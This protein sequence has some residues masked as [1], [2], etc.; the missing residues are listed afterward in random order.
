M[1]HTGEL[2]FYCNECRTQWAEKGNCL[3]KNTTSVFDNTGV[4]DN[5][6][7]MQFMCK[8]CNYVLQAHIFRHLEREHTTIDTSSNQNIEKEI[9]KPDLKLF[10]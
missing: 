3:I 8:W 2:E 9:F 6:S 5:S 7:M 10:A 4:I 1:A